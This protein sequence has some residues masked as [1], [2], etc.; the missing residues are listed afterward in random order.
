M[1]IT[2]AARAPRSDRGLEAPPVPDLAAT[3]L[4]VDLD[5]TIARLEATPQ[6]VGPD[7][8]RRRLLDALLTK[9][10]GRLAV[11]SG[12]TLADLDR[13]LEGRI[14]ALGGVHGLARRNAQGIVFGAVGAERIAEALSDLRA[15]AAADPALMVE[16]KGAAAALHYRR[17]PTAAAAC[18]ELVE[19]LGERLGLE[20][21][22]GS[23]VVEVRAPGPDKGTAVEAFMAE[24]PF[25]GRTPIYLGDDLT[26]E[27]GFRAA[28]ALGGFGV[29][30]GPRRPTAAS[31]ALADVEAAR[32]WLTAALDASP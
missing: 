11:V 18:Q 14:P 29:V 15:F 2:H 13:V 4:F 7:R 21:Q 27:D 22:L 12:R 5:G 25:A 23:M 26:D 9:L 10:E 17:H 30:V 20:V 16:D 8:A 24:A 28:N 3:S 1:A 31:Y 6:A 32:A 19:R